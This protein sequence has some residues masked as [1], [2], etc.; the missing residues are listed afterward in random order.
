MAALIKIKAACLEPAVASSAGGV[1]EPDSAR[2]VV[3]HR[4]HRTL[5]QPAVRLSGA[6]L[7]GCKKGCSRAAACRLDGLPFDRRHRC[8]TA[9]P[10]QGQC[11]DS[12][13]LGASAYDRRERRLKEPPLSPCHDRSSIG[14]DTSGRC[15]LSPHCPACSQSRCARHSRPIRYSRTRGHPGNRPSRRTKADHRSC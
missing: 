6:G 12:G 11:A 8:S 2:C 14:S 9:W 1:L 5:L 15:R 13:K 4:D 10:H 3:A 7:Q